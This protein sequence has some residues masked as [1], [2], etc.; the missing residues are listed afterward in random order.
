MDAAIHG[1][2]LGTGRRTGRAALG[3]S[4]GLASRK[5]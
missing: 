1:V 2:R 3:V 4:S 5:G